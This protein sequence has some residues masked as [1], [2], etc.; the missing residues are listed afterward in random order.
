MG[1]VHKIAGSRTLSL[2]CEFLCPFDKYFIII[3]LFYLNFSHWLNLFRKT[4]D[5]IFLFYCG[6]YYWISKWETEIEM[7]MSDSY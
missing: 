1:M 4:F 5:Y 2:K 6:G 3:Y 7:E